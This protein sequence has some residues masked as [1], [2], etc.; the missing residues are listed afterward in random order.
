MRAAFLLVV[1]AAIAGAGAFAGFTASDRLADPE[2]TTATVVQTRVTTAAGVGAPEA[3]LVKR[4]AIERAAAAGDY[5]ALEDL[6]DDEEFEYTFGGPVAGGPTAYWRRLERTTDERPLESL[7]AVLRMPYTLSRGIYVWPFA[8]D[9]T[10][11]EL[12]EHERELLEPLGRAGAFGEEGY[13]GWRAGIRPD[14]RWVFFV[15]GD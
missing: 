6:A 15:A 13:L 2:V 7:A 11:D 12:T 1:G 10:A 9:K 4:A 14:G 5:A 3:V 8:Y